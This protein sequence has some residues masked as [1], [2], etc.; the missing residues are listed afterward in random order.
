MRCKI[1]KHA[2]LITSL[3][4]VWLLRPEVLFSKD[5]KLGRKEGTRPHPQH[6]PVPQ[7]PPF[8][9][10]CGLATGSPPEAH[11]ESHKKPYSFYKAKMYTTTSQLFHHTTHTRAHLISCVG[12]TTSLPHNHTYFTPLLPLLWPYSLQNHTCVVCLINCHSFTFDLLPHPPRHLEE[13]KSHTGQ[14]TH[15]P[16]IMYWSQ[17]GPDK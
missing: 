4:G 1:S 12:R 15:P 10:K 8:S 11:K 14:K 13:I 7:G 6:Y 5:R 9:I 17:Y 2:H 16:I 3:R